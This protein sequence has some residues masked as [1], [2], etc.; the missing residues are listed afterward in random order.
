[1]DFYDL[2]AHGPPF[3][4]WLQTLIYLDGE[5]Y[6]NTAKHRKMNGSVSCSQ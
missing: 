2:G 5:T 4:T 6:H 1:M 3:S